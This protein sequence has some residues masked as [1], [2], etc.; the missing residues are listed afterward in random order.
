MGREATEGEPMQTSHLAPKVQA[1]NE[2]LRKALEF[3]AADKNWRQHRTPTGEAPSDAEV[4]R[5]KVA[6]DALA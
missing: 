3:Y 5:G 2:R 6:R 1:E 4:D